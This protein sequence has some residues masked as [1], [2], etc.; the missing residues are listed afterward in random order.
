MY[1]ERGGCFGRFCPGVSRAQ[2]SSSLM[3]RFALFATPPLTPTIPNSGF[4]WYEP[5]HCG[6]DA[7]YQIV[8]DE[9]RLITRTSTT[10][11]T[12]TTTATSSTHRALGR[13]RLGGRTRG[14]SFRLT[15]FAVR[16]WAA[17]GM[18][19]RPAAG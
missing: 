2:C 4:D 1:S 15:P 6:Y 11:T 7:S 9:L 14:L 17:F 5:E 3:H 16:R 8:G 10:T 18:P 13:E 12:V 19:G